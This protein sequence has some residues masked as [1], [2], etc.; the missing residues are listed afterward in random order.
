MRAAAAGHGDA[1][2]EG[3]QPADEAALEL[4]DVASV[5]AV[6]T[7]IL[8]R[9]P[10]LQEMVGDNEQAKGDGHGG[11]LLPPAADDPTVRAGVRGKKPCM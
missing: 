1:K 11:P 10:V 5:E 8:A 2:L 9:C 4:A 3:F 7:E 6:S